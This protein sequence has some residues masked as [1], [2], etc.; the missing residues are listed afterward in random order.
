[1][2]FFVVGYACAI[3]NNV[4]HSWNTLNGLGPLEPWTGQTKRTELNI[5]LADRDKG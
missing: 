4:Q 5:P 2:F 3:V 1:M